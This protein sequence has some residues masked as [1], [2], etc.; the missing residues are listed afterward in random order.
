MALVDTEYLNKEKHKSV[1]NFMTF[2]MFK[3]DCSELFLDLNYSFN[4]FSINL[5]LI[6]YLSF[7]QGVLQSLVGT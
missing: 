7:Q 6:S 5:T 4:N 3:T 1:L 2:K